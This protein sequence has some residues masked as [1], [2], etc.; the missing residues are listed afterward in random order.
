MA[1]HEDGENN[2]SDDDF[3]NDIPADALD[4]LENNAIAFTQAQIKAPP[5]SDY[6]DDFDDDDLDDAVVVD[7]ARSAPA[8]VPY[9]PRNNLNQAVRQE[10]FQQQNYEDADNVNRPRDYIGP[11][12]PR[13]SDHLPQPFS[14]PVSRENS[15]LSRQATQL[16]A[17]DDNEA[18][19]RLVQELQEKNKVLEQ[20]TLS[21][22]GEI[23]ILRGRIDKSEKE[24]ERTQ[25]AKEKLH[26]EQLAK[27]QKDREAAETAARNATIERDFTKQDLF[28]ETERAKRLNK[29]K[30][31]K[32]ALVMTPKK[33][34]PMPFRDGFDDDEIELLSPSKMSPSKFQK[35]QPGTPSRAAKRK[36]KA[37][38]S[39]SASALDMLPVPDILSQPQKT[40][41]LDESILERLVLQDDRSDFLA[42]MLDHRPNRDHLRTLEALGKH[43]LPSS[44][45][46]SF[47]SL[48]LG[49]MPRI[50]MK[51][52][53]SEV[54]AEFCL[55]LIQL[56]SKCMDEKFY[57]PIYLFVDILTFALESKTLSI[58]P[59]IIDQ[60]IP[61]VQKTADLVAIPR[62]K[63]EPCDPYDKDIN[64]SACL[65]L[66]HLAALGCVP[67]Q[68]HITRFWK[69]MRWDFVLLMLSQ[70][71][72]V[73]D[74]EWMLRILSTGVL[75]DSFGS[76]PDD[77]PK[78][79]ASTNAGHII[80]RLTYPL[81]E[82][83]CLPM[84]V[85][86]VDPDVVLKLR[87]EIVSLMTGMTR[88]PYAGNALAS[89]PTAIGR[90]ISL[91]S[92]ELD[93]L[94]DHKSGRE[95]SARLISLATRLLFHL[96]TRYEFDMQKKLSVIRGG[97]QKYLLCLARLNFSEDDLVFES[98][99]DPDIP[100]CALE[101][102][103]MVVTPEEGEA[104]QEAL[105]NG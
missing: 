45:K 91:I 78:F 55:F 62:F 76:N 22:N 32:D 95:D 83:P 75:K 87:L 15:N 85:A 46:E 103:E 104:I 74:F 50:G 2:F 53:I 58:V 37:N 69:L 88:S 90:L 48:I 54:P 93:G 39:P 49:E 64:V 6:G 30:N 102:L 26:A 18:L 8:V 9:V 43:S 23:S 86:K 63:S 97:S 56:W 25:A 101:M 98:G 52:P 41:L 89:H 81:F 66:T 28:E 72:P 24:Y 5:S 61:L 65:A 19:R 96:V 51:K 42:A 17:G 100:G 40:P 12:R 10:Q 4:E 14:N 82:V 94:Y 11:A 36:R 84:S 71:Q 7:E 92:D 79:R 35:R 1:P 38:D 80:E 34:K 29:A 21:K 16:V 47:S 20:E 27:L 68:E 59:H 57:T 44:P 73:A 70:N 99:I 77:N 31:S 67:E 33:T 105:S 13:Q 3:L 60:L